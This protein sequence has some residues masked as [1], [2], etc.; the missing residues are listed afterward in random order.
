[1]TSS[2]MT[3]PP[4]LNAVHDLGFRIYLDDFGTGYSSLSYLK[5]FPVDVLKVDKSFV[6]D[7]SEDNN[8]RALVKAIVNMA[9]SLGLAVVAEGVET[10]SQISLLENEGCRYVQGYYF[11]KPV[12]A[13]EFDAAEAHIRAILARPSSLPYEETTR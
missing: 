1:M 4:W 10:L 12:P 13:E 6:R 8:D 7:M 5:R 3:K 2:G 11:S 9:S